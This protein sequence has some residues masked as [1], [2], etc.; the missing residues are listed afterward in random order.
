M[1]MRI[2]A[3]SALALLQLAGAPASSAADLARD[4]DEDDYYAEGYHRSREKEVVRKKEVR[5]YE[6]RRYSERHSYV[7]DEPLPP[8]RRV[9]H[10]P[11]YGRGDYLARADL[12]VDRCTGEV[13][14]ARPLER[15]AYAPFAPETRRSW[16][17]Y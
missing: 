9:W 5:I 2:V 14:S 17:A 16:L 6:Y 7:D 15:R 13:V 4:T 3:A 12:R 1:S 8:R 11:R 10:R